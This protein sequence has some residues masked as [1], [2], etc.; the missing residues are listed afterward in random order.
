MMNQKIMLLL[1]A[2]H[3]GF[4]YA[5]QGEMHRA[6][7]PTDGIGIT[8]PMTEDSLVLGDL[9]VRGITQLLGNANV[10]NNLN[11]GQGL[12]VNNNALIKGNQIVNGSQTFVR[13]T[14]IENN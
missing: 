6:P 4:I 14:T 9:S 1:C 3:G 8:A 5:V 13:D 12:V 11:V 10:R 7:R 2:A